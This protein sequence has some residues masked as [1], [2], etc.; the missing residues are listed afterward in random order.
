MVLEHR[1]MLD[2]HMS[3][4]QKDELDELVSKYQSTSEVFNST[5]ATPLKKRTSR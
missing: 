5:G 4:E 3:K 2:E 1:A